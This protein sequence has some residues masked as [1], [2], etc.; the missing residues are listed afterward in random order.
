MKIGFRMCLPPLLNRFCLFRLKITK[1]GF[2]L[3]SGYFASPDSKFSPGQG[4]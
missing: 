2:R 1:K 4:V 3:V